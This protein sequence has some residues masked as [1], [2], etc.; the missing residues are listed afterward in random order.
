MYSV[1]VELA[2]DIEFDHRNPP[3]LNFDVILKLHVV[4]KFSIS[5]LL[6]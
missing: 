6:P 1:T 2:S 3:V 5:A 4:L